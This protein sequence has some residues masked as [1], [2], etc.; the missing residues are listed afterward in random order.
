MRRMVVVTL[1]MALYLGISC[2]LYRLRTLS[3]DWE[4]LYHSDLILF[5][6]PGVVAGAVSLLALR[7]LGVELATSMLITI[8][9]LVVTFGVFLFVAFNTWGT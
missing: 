9:C 1:T 4:D 7:H 6:F 5:V 3:S 2:G 8:G